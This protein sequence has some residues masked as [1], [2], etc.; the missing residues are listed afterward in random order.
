MDVLHGHLESIEAPGLWDLNLG[1]EPLS[2]VFENNTVGGSKESEHVL[3]EVL[4]TFV[5][6][7]PIFQILTKVNFLGGPEAS[8][9]VLVHLPDVLVLDWKDHES[10]GVVLQEGLWKTAILGLTQNILRS[11]RHIFFGR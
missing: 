6:L 4:L 8:H 5:K 7:V 2:E 1:H 10:V 11:G 9:L 3:D